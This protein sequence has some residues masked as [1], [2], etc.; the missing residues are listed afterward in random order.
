MYWWKEKVMKE[1]KIEDM[2]FEDALAELEEI[3]AS[4]EQRET[5]LKTAMEALERGKAL[6]ELCSS[7]L[8]EAENKLKVFS[9]DSPAEE[10]S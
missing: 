7:R 10:D 2:E 1:E 9:K 6:Y 8:E 5:R 3:A 4:L